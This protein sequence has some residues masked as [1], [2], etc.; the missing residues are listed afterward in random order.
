MPNPHALERRLPEGWQTPYHNDLSQI[1]T[2]LAELTEDFEEH[3]A[4]RADSAT[5]GHVVIDNSSIVNTDNKISVSASWIEGGSEPIIAD[6]G[7]YTGQHGW[8]CYQV[9][10]DL[11]IV[12]VANPTSDGFT[13]TQEHIISD[14]GIRRMAGSCVVPLLDNKGGGT[15]VGLGVLMVASNGNQA[16]CRLYPYG[17]DGA[18]LGSD[19]TY[20]VNA[21]ITL[22]LTHQEA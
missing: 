3:K 8:S 17:L 21:T 7:T 6:D 12:S 13:G 2:D 1:E 15:I 18:A 11:A 20:W 19:V 14:I 10:H 4:T 9:A 16:M 22:P 5:L